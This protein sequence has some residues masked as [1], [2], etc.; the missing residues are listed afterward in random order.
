MRIEVHS[1]FHPDLL[2]HRA[3]SQE[4]MALSTVNIRWWRRQIGFVGQALSLC[5]VYMRDNIR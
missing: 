5:Y 3:P 4:R 2:L 1:N